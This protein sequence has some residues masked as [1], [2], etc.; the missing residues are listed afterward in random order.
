MKKIWEI[1]GA[2]CIC[3]FGIYLVMC[4]DNLTDLISLIIGVIM[5]V[6]GIGE[7][8]NYFSGRHLSSVANGI[9]E[10]VLGIIICL[11][12]SF[13]K[14]LFTILIGIVLICS[15]IMR[16]YIYISYEKETS[17][18]V[19]GYKVL[20]IVGIIFGILCVALHFIIPDMILRII[21]VLLFIYGI[22][23][24]INVFIEGKDND[25]ENINIK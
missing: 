17:K 14:D 15:N 21:G 5:V 1:L 23:E 12:L 22:I 11:H 19:T 2:L 24:V 7:I 3:V 20:S 18:K 10:V 16:L 9:F 13:L 4:A 8:I 25:I 6:S